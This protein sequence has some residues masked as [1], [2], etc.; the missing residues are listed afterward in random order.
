MSLRSY[1]LDGVELTLSALNDSTRP[2]ARLLLDQQGTGKTVQFAAAAGLRPHRPAIVTCPAGL[3]RHWRRDLLRFGNRRAV[4]VES[5]AGAEIAAARLMAGPA[6]DRTLVLSHDNLVD[7]LRSPRGAPWL[8]LLLADGA[9]IDLDEAHRFKSATSQRGRASKQI[10]ELVHKG[11]GM[12][13]W[14]TAT[15]MPQSPIDLWVLL[16]WA[17]LNKVTFGDVFKFGKHFGGWSGDGGRTWFWPAHVPGGAVSQLAGFALRRLRSEV[18]PDMPPKRYKVLRV[19]AEGAARR[20]LDGVAR[21][22]AAAF[23]RSV[24]DVDPETEPQVAAGLAQEIGRRL[25][26]ISGARVEIAKAKIPALLRRLDELEEQGE[27][28]A[29]Y[30][31]HLAPI[32]A[33][34]GD[35]DA[36]PPV[37]GRPGW[38]FIVGD[39][40]D[41]ART[42]AAQAFADGDAQGI[43]FTA[44]GRE[45][46]DLRRATRLII[47]SSPWNHDDQ[48]QAE[49]RPARFG[50]VDDLVIET[51]VISHPVELLVQRGLARK[52][53]RRVE[54][55]DAGAVDGGFFTVLPASSVLP[56]MSWTRLSYE[57]DCGFAGF[58]R[59]DLGV[60]PA[61]HPEERRMGVLFDEA[62]SARLPFWAD[63]P[64]GQT[65]LGPEADAAAKA[66]IREAAKR[67]A[68]PQ[69]KGD[70]ESAGEVAL[71]LSRRAL[72]QFGF[73]SGRFVPYRHHGVAAVQL[74]LRVPLPPPLD[75][76]WAG[77]YQ[78]TDLLVYDTQH[79][80]GTGHARLTVADF[81]CRTFALGRS[82]ADGQDDAQLMLYTAGARKAGI[83]VECALRLEVRGK[84]P[85]EPEL[86]QSKKGLSKNKALFT[87]PELYRA[88]IARHGF[89][90]NDYLEHLEYLEREAPRATNVVQ[91]GR[92]DHALE[93]VWGDMCFDAYR[94][95]QQRRPVRNLRARASSPCHSQAWPC[96]YKEI[97]TGTLSG[98]MTPESYVDDLVRIGRLRR[99]TPHDRRTEDEDLEQEEMG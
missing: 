91:C 10:R 7:A 84:L 90:E 86:L 85:Q 68:W 45:G 55:L 66:A 42:R 18:L 78:K 83:P 87:T 60:R 5:A 30:S 56:Y 41:A 65:C 49:D 67:H 34:R 25:D 15:P 57:R 94:L 24:D 14:S 19:E 69:N 2:P 23:G 50:R 59:Y 1:Q 47:V 3:R 81:K 11:G 58:C 39:E 16:S 93:T 97:C 76:G 95:M 44:A 82:L 61:A 8:R 33:L 62:I 6:E 31:D 54:A 72:V 38:V 88:A 22:A 27:L 70:T 75:Q 20:V 99:T 29:V 28:V 12:T 4:V 51:I 79:R 77:W 35:P 46:F 63:D 9:M 26:E 21:A 43:A 37:P 32:E 74:E 80:G 92:S 64:A 53:Q 73:T 17:G 40:S 48:E 96:E 52:R 71:E 89:S 13:L 36:D 98:H